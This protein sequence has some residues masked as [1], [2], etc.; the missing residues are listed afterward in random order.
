VK[1]G[2]MKESYVQ[3][4]GPRLID[5]FIRNILSIYH[6]SVQIFHTLLFNTICSVFIQAISI[7]PLQVRHYSKPLP[8]YSTDTAGPEFHAE[9]PQAIAS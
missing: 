9:A 3:W 8:T 4:E 6:L 7:A 2:L 1:A 5:D